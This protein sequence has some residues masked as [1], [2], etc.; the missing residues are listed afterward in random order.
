MKEAVFESQAPSAISAGRNWRHY[1][2]VISAVL[3]GIIFLVS[4]G[5][6]VLEPFKTGEL[7]E[8]AQVPGGWGPLGAATLG[9]LELFAA[10]LLFTPRYRRLGGLLVVVR[11]HFQAPPYWSFTRGMIRFASLLAT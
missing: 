7:L 10:L 9:T 6:K 1:A 2:V 8:Q 3:L 4:G 11:R 5:W